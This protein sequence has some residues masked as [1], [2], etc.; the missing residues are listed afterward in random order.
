M[1]MKEKT[2][3]L[4]ERFGQRKPFAFSTTD[5]KR[6][7]YFLLRTFAGDVDL[8][9]ILNTLKCRYNCAFCELPQA[10][11]GEW[12]SGSN[13]IAQFGYVLKEVK[14]AL[15]IL[16]RVTLSNDGSILDE[17]TIPRETILTIVCGIN[18]LRRVHTIVLESRLEFVNK[19]VIQQIQEAAPRARI[20][21]RNKIL[22]KSESL[23]EF[24]AGLD[25]VAECKTDLTSYIIYKPA[26]D[27]TDSEAFIEA[28]KSIDYLVDQCQR[29]SIRLSIR[30]NPM[31]CA[32]YSVWANLAKTARN[33]KPPRI[34]D[35]MKLAEK[36]VQEGISIY[37]GL[38]SEGLEEVGGSYTYRE[39]YTPHL[40]GVMK[41]FNDKKILHFNWD[42]ISSW[43]GKRDGYNYT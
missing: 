39:D 42:E 7:K 11:S 23:E 32:R 27:M 35:I 30:L 8:L 29:R 14:H 25:R 3:Y 13:I 19:D 33:Y 6:P 20:N 9:V 4:Y 22:R 10:S 2:K 28:E 40:I 31:Y 43:D 37:I 38:S 16:D 17:S 21:I 34:T 15:S 41:L 24:L 1:D 5:H 26:P 36:K 18:E 12:I